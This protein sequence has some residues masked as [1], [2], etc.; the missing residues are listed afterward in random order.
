MPDHLRPSAVPRRRATLLALLLL[1]LAAL[2]AAATGVARADGSQTPGPGWV[3]ADAIVSSE[4]VPSGPNRSDCFSRVVRAEGLFEYVPR[5]I[6]VAASTSKQSPSSPRVVI[7]RP[8]CSV[9]GVFITYP[10]GNWHYGQR[11]VKDVS[12]TYTIE[13]G[14]EGVPPE[15][16]R[17][18]VTITSQWRATEGPTYAFYATEGCETLLT[19]I[20][21]ATPTGGGNGTPTVPPGTGITV[22]PTRPGIDRPTPSPPPTATATAT[23]T[24]PVC[25]PSPIDPVPLTLFAGTTNHYNNNGQ[26][27]TPY[28]G[29]YSGA[30][31]S[32]YYGGA[33]WGQMLFGALTSLD[34]IAQDRSLWTRVPANAVVEARYHFEV[35]RRMFDR[36]TVSRSRGAMVILQDLGADMQPGGGDDRLLAFL[37]MGDGNLLDNPANRRLKVQG[38]SRDSWPRLNLP[39]RPS[40]WQALLAPGVQVWSNAFFSWQGNRT[41]PYAWQRWPQPEQRDANG[42]LTKFAEDWLYTNEVGSNSGPLQ[43]R[44]ITEP[45]RA[46][47]MV[48]LNSIPG[49]DTDILST[50]SQLYFETDPGANVAVEKRAPE[51]AARNQ[52]VGYSLTVRNTSQTTVNNVVL[53]DT[54]PLGMPFGGADLT[55]RDPNTGETTTARVTA[56]VS[57]DPSWTDGR[58]LVWNLGNLAPGEVRT[59]DLT[60][61]ATDA[62][63]DAATNVAVVSAANDG[64]PNDNR[65]EATTVFVRTNVGVRITT[66]RI[67]RPGQTFET[68]ITYYNNSPEDATNVLLDYQIVPGITIVSTTPAHEETTA[69]GRLV[70][71]LGTLPAG[72]S[73]TIRVRLQVPPEGSPAMPIALM[74]LARIS[75]DAD[76]N[77]MDNAA[78]A[79]TTVLMV[80]P[81]QRGEERLRIHSEFDPE[82]GVYLSEGTT[83]TWPSGEVMDFTPFIAPDN[84]Q[85]GL[86]YYRLDRRVVAWSFLGSGD[87]NVSSAG[88]KA[89][90]EP[91]A[92]DT[93]HADLSRMRGCIY[94]YRVSPSSAQ[95]RWQGHL[96]WGQHPPERMRQDVYVRTPLPPGG[97]DLRIQ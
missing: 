74:Q 96:F 11:W 61:P 26:P 78:Q 8:P 93:Q 53:T 1:A 87:I 6:P 54:L 30:D 16:R 39:G 24:P 5:R 82:R 71:R 44:F 12:W 69:E 42:R 76:A 94:R 38:T 68:V 50:I 58:T 70:W 15:Y 79:T 57:L 46:Y 90:E 67:V 73:G 75:A 7:D 56:T 52:M 97:T 13:P 9:N 40:G 49:C 86:P 84:R 10:P 72:R 47:R 14:Y 4:C 21:T 19:R 32:R 91:T 36:S 95:M 92:Q 48:M 34:D 17:Y 55:L 89:R 77:P 37:A 81:P 20:P 23:A 25:I 29:R 33:E 2:G 27:F 83:V 63:P 3:K 45:G 80:P 65:A 60:V 64:D 31:G 22:T 85:V 59:I 35:G 43:L 88:C 28:S 18:R 62:A 51:R 66:P 41:P